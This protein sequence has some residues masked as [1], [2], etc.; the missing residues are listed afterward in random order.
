MLHLGASLWYLWIG[1]I[2]WPNLCTQLLTKFYSFIPWYKPKCVHDLSPRNKGNT[3]KTKLLSGLNYKKKKHLRYKNSSPYDYKM[4]VET[5]CPF[6]FP[7]VWQLKYTHQE[8]H[9]YKGTISNQQILQIT[10]EI[11]KNT[12]QSQHYIF[13]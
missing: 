3:R 10:L 8:R 4:A 12:F 7:G 2:I 1:V 9:I 13:F 5:D 6:K 11:K